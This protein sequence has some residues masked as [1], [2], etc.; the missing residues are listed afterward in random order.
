MT[1]YLILYLPRS[2][3]SIFPACESS[4][5]KCSN[6]KCIRSTRQCDTH[7]DCGDNSDEQNCGMYIMGFVSKKLYA[8]VFIGQN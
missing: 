2:L 6:G 7:D 3:N 1:I 5:F 8:V 4:E